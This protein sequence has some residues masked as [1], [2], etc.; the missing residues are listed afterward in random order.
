MSTRRVHL[1][2]CRQFGDQSECSVIDDGN[3]HLRIDSSAILLHATSDG[4]RKRTAR[5][6]ATEEDAQAALVAAAIEA[7]TTPATG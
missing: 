4:A 3:S 5:P 7:A 1:D 6:A 2:H